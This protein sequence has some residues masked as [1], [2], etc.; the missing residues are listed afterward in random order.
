MLHRPP[1][2][3]QE[4]QC[5]RA[6]RGSRSEAPSPYSG[7]PGE[8][9]FLTGARLAPCHDKVGPRFDDQLFGH[10]TSKE[11]HTDGRCR[12][13]GGPGLPRKRSLFEARKT[14]LGQRTSNSK[15]QVSRKLMDS[16]SMRE[17]RPFSLSAGTLLRDG[18]GSFQAWKASLRQA[19]WMLSVCPSAQVALRRQPQEKQ[20]QSRMPGPPLLLKCPSARLADKARCRESKL[21]AIAQG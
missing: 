7:P 8:A 2:Y 15:G 10:G 3:F 4:C 6:L 1:P 9:S 5:H 18:H 16:N 17:R 20:R 19:L 13:A 11:H 14:R 12:S 21:M